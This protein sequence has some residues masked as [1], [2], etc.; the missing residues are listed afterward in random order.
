MS[1]TPRCACPFRR[2]RERIGPTVNL[3]SNLKSFDSRINFASGDFTN[4]GGST[5]DVWQCKQ[6]FNF[7][8]VAKLP[9]SSCPSLSFRQFSFARARQEGS[10]CAEEPG[11]WRR[12]G[13]MG[14]ANSPWE[15]WEESGS[16][17]QP[18]MQQTRSYYISLPNVRRGLGKA[19]QPARFEP[20]DRPSPHTLDES[21]NCGVFLPQLLSSFISAPRCKCCSCP[22]L[23]AP[24]WAARLG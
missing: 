7:L 17:S 1:L 11:S 4:H 8:P 23:P 9:T 6:E 20:H 13:G 14:F 16:R 2:Q 21:S 5:L 18:W 12:N 10:L 15:G 19:G 22:H 24:G 3:K